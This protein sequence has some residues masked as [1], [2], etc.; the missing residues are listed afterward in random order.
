MT[1][2]NAE[3]LSELLDGDRVP[4]AQDHIAT[5][6]ACQ[7]ELET[8]R[9]LRTELRELPLLDP[10]AELWS[11]IEARL[12][13]ARARWR[14]GRPSQVA[15]QVA[16]MAAVFVIG[17]GV[18]KL[19]LAESPADE[20]AGPVGALVA[21]PQPTT[22][23][24]PEAMAEV[25]RLAA[26]YDAAILNLQRLAGEQGSSVPPSLARQRLANLEALVEAS[27]A[28]LATDPGDPTLNSYL[29]AA[30]EERDNLA[31][32]LATARGS[33]SGVVWR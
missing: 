14:V 9:K 8:L 31:R 21:E 33:G 20:Y 19:F 6:G 29:F 7:D 17:L 10:P 28:A 22:V 13:L 1:H 23:S 16:A 24:L 30:I 32:Q 11:E 18:G 12:P 27:R 25:R 3:T 2:L 5:C 15:L 4:G 26:E